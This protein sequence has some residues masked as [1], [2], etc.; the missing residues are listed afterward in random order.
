MT[1]RQASSLDKWQLVGFIL[2]VMNTGNMT[3][4]GETINYGPCSFMETYDASTVSSSIDYQGCCAYGNQPY[5]R[6]RFAETLLSLQ[7]DNQDKAIK[8]FTETIADFNKLYHANLFAGMR[9][10]CGI[11]NEEEQDEP[12]VEADP[13]TKKKYRADY[14]KTFRALIY[15]TW[16]ETA[17]FNS[18]ELVQ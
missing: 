18:E 4:S 3:I 12:V 6:W 5:I 8:M 17:L 11:F 10:N 15:E 9:A 13:K 1:K 7:H 2:G 16:D 14:T